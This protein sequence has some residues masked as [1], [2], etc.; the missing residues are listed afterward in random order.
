MIETVPCKEKAHKATCVVTPSNGLHYSDGIKVVRKIT[1]EASGGHPSLT[2]EEAIGGVACVSLCT[3][4]HL[5]I[6]QEDDDEYEFTPS[7][8]EWL[9]WEFVGRYQPDETR[10]PVVQARLFLNR[11]LQQIGHHEVVE[12][13]LRLLDEGKITPQ[14][15]IEK[16][17]DF[18]VGGTG[19]PVLAP[20]FPSC[21]G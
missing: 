14:E 15:A 18:A 5:S 10:P 21:T 13:L 3:P 4:H 12:S 8:L 19:R 16:G 9:Q 6:H 17:G 20:G 2:V 7:F 11:I 1:F